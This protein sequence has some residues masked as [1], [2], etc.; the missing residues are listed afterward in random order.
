MARSQQREA[1]F[2]NN[3]TWADKYLIQFLIWNREAENLNSIHDSL[4]K[5]VRKRS[6]E[7]NKKN[8][9]ENVA[10]LKKSF[11][12]SMKNYVENRL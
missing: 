8:V 12:F 3:D 4:K 7:K 2:V 11:H 6:T 10:C 5:Y 1:L 9:C